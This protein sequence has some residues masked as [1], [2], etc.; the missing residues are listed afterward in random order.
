[1]ADRTGDHEPLFGTADATA[2][3]RNRA[4]ASGLIVVAG[5]TVQIGL[6]LISIAVLARLLTPEDFGV[7]ALVLPVIVLTNAVINLRLNVAALQHEDLDAEGLGRIFRLSMRFNLLIVIIVAAL[8]P[9]LGEMYQDARV[10]A[11]TAAWAGA[12]YILNLGAFHEALLK[13]QMRFGLTT[14]IETVAMMIGMV[15]AVLAASLGAGYWALVLDIACIG[16][17]RSIGAWWA[18]P[19]RPTRHVSR[20]PDARVTEMVRFGRNLTGF[21]IVSWVGAQTDRILVGLFGG[22]SVLGLYDG[23]RRWGWLPSVE[24]DAAI[25]DVAIS[26][27]SRAQER[28]A[29]FQRLVR[30]AVSAILILALPVTAFIFVEAEGSVRLLFGDQWLGAI[31]FMRVMCFGAFFAALARPTSWIFKALGRTRR[32]FRWGLFQTAII[33]A[34]LLTGS[35]WG[36]MGIAVGY[37]GAHTALAFPTIWFCVRGTP[38]GLRDY[39]AAALRPAVAACIAGLAAFGSIRMLG[40][41]GMAA[42]MTVEF[43]VFSVLY[44]LTWIALPGGRRAARDGWWLIRELAKGVGARLRGSAPQAEESVTG[45]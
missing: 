27:F 45:A 20:E 33:L 22:A 34:A 38:V 10:V 15:V 3:L 1:M 30:G 19:W 41:L 13:R 2:E 11:V 23:A 35:I 40:D 29:A 32:Q 24:L 42:Q 43:A 12:I 21:Q 5:R 39:L 18:C 14:I 37:A 26:S 16:V 17:V 28:P 6:R 9:L 4:A 31:P 36:P 7:R 25:S 8:G 44:I